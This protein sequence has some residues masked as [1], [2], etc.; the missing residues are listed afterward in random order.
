MH[1]EVQFFLNMNF[2]VI[3]AYLYQYNFI[4]NLNI[5]K[6]QNNLCMRISQQ[7]LRVHTWDWHFTLRNSSSA[8]SRLEKNRR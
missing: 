4:K 3:L 5:I 2:D 1:T 6:M 7:R 8:C